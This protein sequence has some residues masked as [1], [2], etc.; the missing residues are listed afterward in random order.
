MAAQ[1]YLVLIQGKGPTNAQRS[2]T[3]I[4]LDWADSLQRWVAMPTDLEEQRS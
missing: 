3:T 4:P 1:Q 2:P